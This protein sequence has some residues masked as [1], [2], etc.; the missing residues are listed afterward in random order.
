[1]PTLTAATLSVRRSSGTL[2][3]ATSPRSAIASAMYPPVID[4]VRVPASACSTSQ[5][6][7]MVRSPSRERS[8]TLRSDRPIRRWISWVRPPGRPRFTSRGDRSFVEAGSIEYSPVTH[9]LPVPF[10]HRGASSETEAATSTR[11]RPIENRIE[12]AAHSWKPSSHAT[13]RSS[14]DARPSGRVT[15]G[16]RA[17]C[18]A[19]RRRRDRR[20]SRPP[21][22]WSAR[23]RGRGAGG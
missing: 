2:P 4:A 20:R 15:D 16:P 21:P 8:V 1:M 17:P 12:P 19:W 5:S 6:T 11:V 10:S 18:R 13:G 3:S 14:S 9:P 22:R 23:G 7:V